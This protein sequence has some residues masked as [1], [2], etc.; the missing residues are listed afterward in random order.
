V[1]K[2]VS[3]EEIFNDADGKVP[4]VAEALESL[5]ESIGPETVLSNVRVGRRCDDSVAERV[6]VDS[7]LLLAF[8][9]ENASAGSVKGMVGLALSM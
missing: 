4:F 7:V 5:C 2:D 9:R 3:V 1:D 8:G 6:T